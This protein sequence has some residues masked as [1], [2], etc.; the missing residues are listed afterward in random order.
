MV[1]IISVRFFITCQDILHDN[2]P[3]LESYMFLLSAYFI[4]DLHVMYR[5]HLLTMTSSKA[6]AVMSWVDR[7][8]DFFRQKPSLVIHHLLLEIAGVPVVFVSLLCYN[9]VCFI[10]FFKVL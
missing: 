7:V 2:D 6:P 4:Y 8:L 5:G 1:S 9:V 3:V 10:F